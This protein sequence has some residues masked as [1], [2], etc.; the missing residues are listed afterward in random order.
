VFVTVA[1]E[2][3]WYRYEVDLADEDE[4]VRVGRQG[5]DLDELLPEERE[6]NAVCEANGLLALTA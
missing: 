5:G 6:P 3:S 2:L 4:P 1:W